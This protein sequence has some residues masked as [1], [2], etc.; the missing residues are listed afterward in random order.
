[1][2]TNISPKAERKIEEIYTYIAKDNKQAAEK[3][4]NRIH[5]IVGLISR[6]PYLGIVG[7]KE[8]TREFFIPDTNYFIVYKIE[9]ELL[10]IVNVIHVAKNY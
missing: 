2:K 8:N 1:M 6:N 7:R 9:K 4:V 5:G 10:Y 3:T